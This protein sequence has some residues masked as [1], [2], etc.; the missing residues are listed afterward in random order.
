MKQQIAMSAITPRKA[1]ATAGGA[2]AVPGPGKAAPMGRGRSPAPRGVKRRPCHL[3]LGVTGRRGSTNHLPCPACL[4]NTPQERSLIGTAP[5]CHRC[6]PR[7]RPAVTDSLSQTGAFSKEPDS[8]CCSPPDPGVNEKHPKPSTLVIVSQF[9][10]LKT[11]NKQHSARQGLVCWCSH[12]SHQAQQR[13]S[14]VFPPGW[15]H[16]TLDVPEGAYRR[17]WHHR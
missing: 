3:L 14:K 2:Q 4:A 1:A 6:H 9:L 17:S 16:P 11:K 15:S 8:K 10:A 12:P 5:L 13:F 7:R